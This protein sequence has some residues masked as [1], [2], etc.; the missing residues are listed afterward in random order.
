[1]PEDLPFFDNFVFSQAIALGGAEIIPE[2]LCNYRLHSGS[3]YAGTTADLKRNRMRYRLLSTLLR[4]L[5]P[6]LA[7][8]GAQEDAITAF[9]AEDVIDRDRL[10]LMLEGGARIETYQ[11]ESAAFKLS[12]T[13]AS[14][15]RRAFKQLTLLAS[16]VLPPKAFYCVHRWY[17][18]HD[19]KR[20]RGWLGG[21]DPEASRAP[22]RQQPS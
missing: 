15:G 12:S 20:L 5:P 6:R 2:A 13:E 14:F 7:G 3:L 1:V 19:L 11:V 22:I 9:F 10:R 8:L 16:L 21:S 4:Q 18:Q 17:G